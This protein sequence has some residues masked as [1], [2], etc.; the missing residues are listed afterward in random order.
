MQP[1][2][3]QD[4]IEVERLSRTELQS[5]RVQLWGQKYSID[6]SL[7]AGDGGDRDAFG[8]VLYHVSYVGTLQCGERNALVH[9]S[10]KMDFMV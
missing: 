9:R 8:S 4:L 5:F 2:V 6:P 7:S 3:L 1:N 10:T